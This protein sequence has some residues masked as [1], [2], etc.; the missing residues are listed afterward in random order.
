M[1]VKVVVK[2][3]PDGCS[4]AKNGIIKVSSYLL[5]NLCVAVKQNLRKTIICPVAG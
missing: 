5:A 2:K 4:L 3:G 1:D